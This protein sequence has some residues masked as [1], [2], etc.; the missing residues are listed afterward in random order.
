MSQASQ[1]LTGTQVITSN[2]RESQ[3]TE[4]TTNTTNSHR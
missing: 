1:V 3:V 2:D 4:I